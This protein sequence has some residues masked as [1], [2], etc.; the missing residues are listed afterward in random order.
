MC[1]LFWR[2]A[3]QT[4]AQKIKQGGV[5]QGTVG[6]EAVALKAEKAQFVCAGSR[7]GDQP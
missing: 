3:C 2:L 6:L 5:G 1:D 7:L 4:S